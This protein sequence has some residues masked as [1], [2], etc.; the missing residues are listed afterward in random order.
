MLCTACQDV[1]SL[2]KVVESDPILSSDKNWGRKQPRAR[3]AGLERPTLRISLRNNCPVPPKR[4][5]TVTSQLPSCEDLYVVDKH[6]SFCA[7]FA[8]LSMR[9]SAWP[10]SELAAPIMAVAI[11]RIASWR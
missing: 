9:V 2:T 8:Y 7:E 1:N 11:E 3:H 6:L 5:V 4:G 10:P